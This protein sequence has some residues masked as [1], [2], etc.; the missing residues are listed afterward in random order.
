[1]RRQQNRQLFGYFIGSRYEFCNLRIPFCQHEK[2]G[3]LMLGFS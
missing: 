2:A 3:N 1:M